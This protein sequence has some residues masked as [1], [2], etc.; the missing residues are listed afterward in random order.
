M[1]AKVFEPSCRRTTRS[2]LEIHDSLTGNFLRAF[3]VPSKQ[4]VVKFAI[5]CLA[6]TNV[7]AFMYES[8]RQNFELRRTYWSV[9]NLN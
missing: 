3:G 4:L 2:V 9:N 7:E 5:H 8:I 1:V 6:V